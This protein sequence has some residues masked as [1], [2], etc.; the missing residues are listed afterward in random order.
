MEQNQNFELL[1]PKV[2][3]EPRGGE[4]IS[5]IRHRFNAKIKTITVPEKSVKPALSFRTIFLFQISFHFNSKT[6]LKQSLVVAAVVTI[7]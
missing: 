6:T 5:R 4:S 7:L 2:F 1:I 3:I